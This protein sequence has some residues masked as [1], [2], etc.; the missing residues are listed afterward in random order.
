MILRTFARGRAVSA[1]R[2]TAAWITLGVLF[3]LAAL[4]APGC[5]NAADKQIDIL[6]RNLESGSP[7]VVDGALQGLHDIGP[8][9]ERA[10]PAVG[11]VL[12]EGHPALRPPAAIVLAKINPEGSKVIGYL[13]DALS[14]SDPATRAQAA[15]GVG[16]IHLPLDGPTRD[17]LTKLQK[18]P[19]PAVRAFVF[20][21]LAV[22]TSSEKRYAEELR[23]IFRTGN[24]SE[25]SLAINLL[26]DL[27]ARTVD[28]DNSTLIQALDDSALPV[29]TEAVIALAR[30]GKR[31]EGAIPA[32]MRTF[33]TPDDAL[34]RK[35]LQSMRTIDPD[36]KLLLPEFRRRILHPEGRV[37]LEAIANVGRYGDQALSARSELIAALSDSDGRVRREAARTLGILGAKADA[38][39]RLAARLDDPSQEAAW[40]SAEALGKM[41]P[42]ALP[43]IKALLSSPRSAVRQ[44]A[45]YALGRLEPRSFEIETLLK[46]AA[47]DPD[48]EVSTSAKAALNP[49]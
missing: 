10:V 33:E 41:G 2:T 43:H 25:R 1:A 17:L 24:P 13:R 21:A 5:R 38:S 46:K 6:I 22:K 16:L 8:G 27:L 14:D 4:S 3:I 26:G 47:E 29:K 44:K 11:K 30:Q 39:A 35:T 45:V 37:R 9:A 31:A 23:G 49:K 19:T 28:G 40:A 12:K 36:G 18:D 34:A 42:D 15:R 48:S 7:A 20:W 32:L